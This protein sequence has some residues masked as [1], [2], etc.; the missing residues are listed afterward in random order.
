[1]DTSSDG[2]VGSPVVDVRNVGS[3]VVDVRNVSVVIHPMSPQLVHQLQASNQGS[4]VPGPSWLQS[5]VRP[6][7]VAPANDVAGPS[8]RPPSTPQSVDRPVQVRPLVF[9]LGQD[10]IL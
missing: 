7:F 10:P 4:P 2:D 1:M 9:R 3:P 6:V 5:P 8:F